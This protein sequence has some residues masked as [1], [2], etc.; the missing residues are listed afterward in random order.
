MMAIPRNRTDDN[1]NN[2]VHDTEPQCFATASLPDG[3]T[4]LDRWLAQGMSE[5][6]YQAIGFVQVG[7]F[8]SQEFTIVHT[9]PA[10]S[11]VD[12]NVP[13]DDDEEQMDSTHNQNV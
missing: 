8:T 5:D 12:A 11:S 1:K 2:R 4:P 3:V 6:P 9:E 10:L 13:C 7:G